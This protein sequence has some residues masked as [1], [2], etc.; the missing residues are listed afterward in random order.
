M[1]IIKNSNFILFIPND[2]III[3]IIWNHFLK[4]TLFPLKNDSISITYHNHSLD[5]YEKHSVHKFH[6]PMISLKNKLFSAFP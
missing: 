3:T 1:K 2:S 4:E 6:Y 5:F